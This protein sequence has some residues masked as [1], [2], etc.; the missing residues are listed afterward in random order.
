MDTRTGQHIVTPIFA[1]GDDR[2]TRRAALRTARI[3]QIKREI[4]SA[5]I[6]ALKREIRER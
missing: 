4:R 6:A 5:R 3:D 1:T 2:A